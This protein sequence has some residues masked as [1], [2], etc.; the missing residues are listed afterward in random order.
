MTRITHSTPLLEA[1]TLCKRFGGLTALDGVSFT[2]YQGE[3]CGLI[4]PNGAGKTTLFNVITGLYTADSGRLLFAG[5]A[6]HHAQPYQIAQHGIARTFQNIRLFSENININFKI[7][8]MS[9]QTMDSSH[10]S[11]LELNIPNIW[12][13]SYTINKD[14]V[15]GINTVL[16]LKVLSTR[17]KGQ[18]IQIILPI[19]ETDKINIKF[20]S[21]K[22]IFNK[23]FE[24]PMVDLD[25]DILAIPEMEYQA[26]FSL[27]SSHFYGL[28]NQLKLFGDCLDIL[29]SEE[30]ITL[31]SNSVDSGKMMVNIDI[32][33]PRW[34]Q[35]TY[36]GRFQHFFTTTNPLNVLASDEELEKAKKIVVDYR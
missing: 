27:P 32:D 17:E 18:S 4:G 21:E 3:I 23:D 28:V 29:C 30:K 36:S 16:F 20:E 14:M 6:I 15:V 34:D 13:D 24:V 26:E 1:S 5:Q 7:D 2:V 35:S 9:I 22:S 10:V 19:D 31:C 33:K 11:I 25:T 12:F 8:A